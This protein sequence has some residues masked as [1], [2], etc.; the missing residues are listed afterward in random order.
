MNGTDDELRHLFKAAGHSRP[1]VDLTQR[2]M[3][4][5]AVTPLLRPKPSQPL[6]SR[7]AWSGIGIG[8][9]LVLLCAVIT[10]PSTAAS[11]SATDLA[12]TT[13]HQALVQASGWAPWL[14]GISVCMVV[15]TFIDRL[16]IARGRTVRGL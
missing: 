4:Q 3:A 13:L 5:V 15:L 14:L 1:A 10:A 16:L 12:R 7:R 8:A 11:G 9:A 6:L 2:I